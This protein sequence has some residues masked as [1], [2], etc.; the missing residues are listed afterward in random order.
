LR[1]RSAATITLAPARSPVATRCPPDCRAIRGPG[2]LMIRCPQ[3]V[4]S[5]RPPSQPCWGVAPNPTRA[6]PWTH[7][8]PK[9]PWNPFL[10]RNFPGGWARRVSTAASFMQGGSAGPA[11]GE[12]KGMGVW[13]LRPQ[14]VQGSA[15]ALL[16]PDPGVYA[17]PPS[18]PGRRCQ[19]CTNRSGR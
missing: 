17:M 13:G 10:T 2:C 9:G 16:L 6:L 5:D 1:W 3:W 12:L 7:Q 14:R 15:L 8:G 18:T 11:G 4:E 19:R